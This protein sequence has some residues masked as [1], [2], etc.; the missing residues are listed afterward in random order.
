MKLL[1]VT[2]WK[3]QKLLAETLRETP[4]IQN[5]S[6]AI[7]SI[8]KAGYC[9]RRILYRLLSVP[10]SVLRGGEQF[11]W[12]LKNDILRFHLILFFFFFFT[13]ANVFFL[14]VLGKECYS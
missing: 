12:F 4:P 1:K 11:L 14:D 9:Y 2:F 13:Q 8:S 10:S 3:S 6:I 5:N 7:H